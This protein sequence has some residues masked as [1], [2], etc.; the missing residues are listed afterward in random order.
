MYSIK[1]YK[2][3]TPCIINNSKIKYSVPIQYAAVVIKITHIILVIVVDMI[4][5]NY[6]FVV[7]YIAKITRTFVRI[8]E[9]FGK[10]HYFFVFLNIE[11]FLYC[12]TYH[13]F[14]LVVYFS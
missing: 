3:N 14:Y 8:P 5:P 10:I 4:I 11:M 6:L 2:N 9:I 7:T 12:F 13:I 1:I